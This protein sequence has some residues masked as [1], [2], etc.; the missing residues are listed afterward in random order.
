MKFPPFALAAA[1]VAAAALPARPQNC[2]NTSVGFTPLI[3]LGAGT[4]CPS[5]PCFEGGLYPG[6]SNERP[7]AHEIGGL[8]QAKSVVPRNAAGAPDPSGRI[9]VMSLGM[10]NCVI[11]WNGFKQKS[12]ADP[13]RNPRIFLFQG[14]Q[15]GIAAEDMDEAGEPY[16]TTILPQ[17]LQQA[18]VQ[19]AEVQVLWFLQANRQPSAPF[20][21]HALT[22]KSQMESILRIA[23]SKLPNARIAYAASRIYAGYATTN[24]NPEPYA[25][26][27]AFAVK[28]MIEDQM[29]GDPAL[30]YDPSKGPVQAPWIAWGPYSW[31]D[32]LIPRSDGLTWACSDFK[33][34]GTHPSAQGASKNADLLL[35]FFHADTTARPW[36]LAAPDPVIYG[37]GK[38]T[39]LGS[40]PA[41]GWGGTPSASSQDFE[42]TLAGALPGKI[43]IAFHGPAPAN[44]PFFGGTLYVGPPQDRLPPKPI[45]PA[46]SVSFPIPVAPWMAGLSDHFQVWFRDPAH[47]DGTAVGLSNALQVRWR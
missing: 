19:A 28:W 45:G 30:N 17:K 13:L 20:P 18:G 47:P 2:G 40:L 34:D 1:V 24:L 43:A 8:A 33:A 32:G 36:Y 12:N 15:G 39:S 42:V 44:L 22:L 10:S 16:W 11:H 23:R 5:G 21:Q 25:Y 29:G 27:Q 35:G 41:I 3:D 26:E 9:V 37:T 4:Y 46:G 6:G 31:A 7:I 14:A 38:T